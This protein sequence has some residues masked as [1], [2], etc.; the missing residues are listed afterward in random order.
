MEDLKAIRVLQGTKI[1]HDYQDNNVTTFSY[2]HLVDIRVP[3]I[4]IPAKQ[5]GLIIVDVDGISKDHRFDGRAWW[6][7]FAKEAGMPPTYT[8]ST[9]SGGYH[10]YFRLPVA[11]NPDTFS[12]PARL[13]DGVDIKYNGWVAA[14]P[15]QGYRAV[16][17]T[18]ADI[19][20]APPSLILEM[21]KVRDQGKTKSYDSISDP[22]AK[23][24][25][26]ARPFNEAQIVEIRK[27][28]EWMQQVGELSYDEWRDGLFA[29]KAGI[30]DNPELLDDLAL[31]WT[32]NRTYQSGDEHKA[33][34]I[35]ERADVHGGVGPGSIF[36]IFKNVALRS[37]APVVA[38]PYNRV[39]II[40]RSKVTVKISADGASKVA[41]T[42]SNVAALLGAM[43]DAEYLYHD[44][45]N[46]N[47]VYNGRVYSDIELTN[48]FAP[49]IQSTV[50][51]LGFENIKKAT[52][53]SGLDVLM[54]AR[55]TDPYKKWLE[56]LVWDGVPR[57][58]RFFSRYVNTEDSAYT[59][60]VS[61]NLWIALAAR[62]IDPGCK[63]D[64]V[65]VLEGAEGARKSTLCEIIGGDYYMC[66]SSDESIN[67]PD[68][69][70][71]MHQSTIVELPEL[72]GLLGKTGEEV[73][74]IIT[75]RRDSM[76]ALYARKGVVKPRGFVFIGTTNSKRYL[77]EDMGY[78]RY[79]P[80][81]IRGG[82]CVVKTEE[83]QQDREQLFAEAVQRYKMGETFWEEPASLRDEVGK[84]LNEEPLVDPIRVILTNAFGAMK[85]SDIYKHLETGGF[86]PKGLSHKA[87]LR[88]SR[89]LKF[90]GAE[91]VSEGGAIKW[92]IPQQSG[93]DFFI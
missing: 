58:D 49:M 34:D 91:E 92:R 47:F 2:Q 35:I 37:G 1:S 39:E 24:G 4:G 54:A 28:I 55:Q 17:G 62:G 38:S 87:A 15:T 67:S 42:E 64:N 45:R 73:K 93:A 43:F 90:I 70:R 41:P 63:F 72:I 71:K 77:S 40:N 75:T 84:R 31:Q 32:Y 60:G 6:E 74:A 20:E 76:R 57:V 21:E 33:R 5:N 27:R 12:P 7:N 10:C 85:L 69:L 29:L 88:I 26:L 46:D 18:I 3:A 14:P 82:V 9:P 8:V 80:I 36:A 23:L 79:W 56:S 16:Y 59:R 13:A 50:H 22:F 51:G 30:P 53:Q 78:R 65:V 86:L 48:I 19:E 44:V 89:A 61:K 52:I 11:I 66:M 68:T 81:E 83:I 25:D